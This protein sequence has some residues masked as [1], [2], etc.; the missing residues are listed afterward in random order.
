MSDAG[1]VEA[2]G[3]HLAPAESATP[4]PAGYSSFIAS[5]SLASV[6]VVAVDGERRSAGQ[7]SHT[8]FDLEAG[9]RL[10]DGVVRYRFS[11][12]GHLTDEEEEDYGHVGASVV[13]TVNAPKSPDPACVDL[14]GSTSATMI[15]QPYLRETIATTAQRIGFAGILL[16]ML[17]QQLRP[18]RVMQKE[19]PT[20]LASTR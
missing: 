7:P 10:E 9:Y 14:F 12:T 20:D 2:A 15:A 19:E 5:V 16:P 4:D 13:V 6:D 17:I 8:R 18:G 3:T 1:Q 11:V